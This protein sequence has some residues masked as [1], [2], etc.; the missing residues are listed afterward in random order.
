MSDISLFPQKGFRDMYPV[1]KSQQEYIFSNLRSIAALH[2]FQQYDGP[3]LEDISIYLEKTSRELIDRQTF[4]VKDRN[5][6]TLVLR[7]EMTPSLARMIANKSHE[8][9]FPLRV[10]NIGLRFRYEAPQKGREREFYQAD[11]DIL[12][13]DS[14]IADVEI[15]STAIAIFTSF[16]AT[17]KDFT[18]HINSRRYI[19]DTFVGFGIV[20]EDIGKILAIIDKKDKIAFAE[21]DT[22]LSTLV[23]TDVK[24]K[25]LQVLS[26]PSHASQY[27][28]FSQLLS[29]L[30]KLHL[31][32][33]VT[34]DTTIVRGLDYYTGLVF[35]VKE[36]GSL[37]RSMLGGGRYDNL[38]SQFNEKLNIPGVGFAT[39]DVVLQAF[40]TEK[41]L[42]PPAQPVP[43]KVLVTIFDESVIDDAM[44]VAHLLR[45]EHIPTELFP[46]ANK[47][48]DK[49]IKYADKNNIP[50][51]III[52]PEE[53][54]HHKLN[55][56]ALAKHTQVTV[57]NTKEAI[58]KVIHN[59]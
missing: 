56:K 19:E 15:I 14:I 7:P 17:E 13:T 41:E 1:Q 54:Q 33:Y 35:E 32:Q 11:F 47:K 50:F 42:L 48:I 21:F 20:K 36:I 55:I 53:A 51:V 23:S 24:A 29:Y 43:T 28:Y 39:S 4:Q 49:Q 52:G 5:D 26:D 59:P 27:T 16:G 57:D 22:E 38:V 8:L 25:V 31:D 44:A 46:D 12:G 3:I 40:L 10:S 30:K 37:K 9:I 58:L 34:I 6:K 45:S 2:G 18:V